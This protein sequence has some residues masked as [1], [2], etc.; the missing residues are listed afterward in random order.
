MK[1]ALLP[2][3]QGHTIVLLGNFNPKIFQPI[4]FST[5]EL[6]QKQEAE[7]ANI[8]IIHPD[9]TIFS[10]DWLRVTVTPERFS[11]ETTQ[12]SYYEAVR[13]L[14]IGTFSLLRHT[15]ITKM[16]INIDMMNS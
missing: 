1:M 2:K 5:E 6:L 15:P 9:V 14:I 11:A 16:G 3:I 13:D 8:E 10:L 12:E 7:K 4:W